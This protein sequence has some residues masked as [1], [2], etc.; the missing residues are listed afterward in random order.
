[1]AAA[2]GIYIIVELEGAAGQRVREV[3]EKYDPKLARLNPPHLTLAGSSG[4]GA[5]PADTKVAA[6]RAA[7]EPIARTTAPMSLALGAPIRFMQTEIVVL[8]MD[9][10]GPLRALHERIAQ[11][12]LEF[13]PARFS[14]TPHITMSFFPTLTPAIERELLAIRVN[15][16]AIVNGFQIYLTRDPQPS[17]KLLDLDLTGSG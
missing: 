14:F 9:P 11:S 16:P 2:I 13:K 6:L 12:G 17:R 4:V 3:Q 15:E 5:I 10:N 8:P 1:M 7:L